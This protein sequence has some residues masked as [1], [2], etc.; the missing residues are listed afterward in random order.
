ML[1][2]DWVVRP[3]EYGME[4]LHVLV[5][6]VPVAATVSVSPKKTG[7]IV[8]EPSAT[9]TS[10]LH[11]KLVRV[12]VLTVIVIVTVTVPVKTVAAGSSSSCG[13]A[14][15]RG[16]NAPV[17]GSRYPRMPVVAWLFAAWPQ[18]VVVATPRLQINTIIIN[19]F[20][21]LII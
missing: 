20:V 21:I 17:W 1:S 19:S 9:E 6:P 14:A 5:E 18:D 3:Q 11:V 7:L 8:V 15:G 13:T 2:V 12:V 4:S 10:A 16:R